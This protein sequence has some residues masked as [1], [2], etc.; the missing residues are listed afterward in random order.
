LLV[1]HDSQLLVDETGNATT[2]GRITLRGLTTSGTDPQ[3]ALTLPN[4]RP[5]TAEFGGAV[6]NIN[7]S[8]DVSDVLQIS[9]TVGGSA[10][11]LTKKG[12]GSAVFT[13]AGAN[14]FAGQTIVEGGT[15]ELNKPRGVTALHNV[16]IK[17]GATLRLLQSDQ[18]DDNATIQLTG[19]GATLD[20]N[21]RTD[22][23]GT[24][25]ANAQSVILT[26][27]GAI[28]AT[29][30]AMSGSA[31]VAV[32]SFANG[33]P[34]L[35]R[36]GHVSAASQAIATT[37][38]SLASG[39]QLDLRNNS[40]I[41]NYPGPTP[42]ATFRAAI[43]TAY[44]PTATGHWTGPGIT[45]SNAASDSGAAVGYAEASDVLSALLASAGTNATFLGQKVDDTSIV[46]RYTLAGDAT[47]DG[48]VNFDDLV[49]LAQ[50]YNIAGGRIWSG[51]DFTYDGNV[52][53]ADLVLLAQNYNV[54]LPGAGA[55]PGAPADFGADLA[56]AFATV[57]EP[58]IGWFVGCAA[59]LMRSRRRP[60]SS[61][62]KD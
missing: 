41:V 37:S 53:F 27:G 23:V 43:V 36:Q 60:I 29:S 3:V 1:T 44:S 59:V 62:K 11:L 15:L 2:R 28:S 5:L 13:G 8:L 4:A 31:R 58:S 10:S 9:G 46:V 47:L 55:I 24:I 38:L 57:P 21:G 35:T 48:V 16:E 32:S 14:T 20:L 22:L 49:R 33:S 30:I 61:R 25:T 45:S 7:T 40:L 56:A 26:N 39:A 12:G 6:F 17:G 34:A 42:F 52:N 18:L 50:N 51:G 19:A 54:G